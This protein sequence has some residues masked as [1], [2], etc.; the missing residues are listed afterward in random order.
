MLMCLIQASCRR[1]ATNKA[2][3]TSNNNKALSARAIDA[4]I[5]TQVHALRVGNQGRRELPSVYPTPTVYKTTVC[6]PDCRLSTR[7]ARLSAAVM[8]VPRTQMVRS[9]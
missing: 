5:I 1:Q 2:R 3:M 7:L 8:G 6:L 9:S 4:V